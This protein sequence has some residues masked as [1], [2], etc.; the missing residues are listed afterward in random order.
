MANNKKNVSNSGFSELN[1]ELILKSEPNEIQDDKIPEFSINTAIKKENP[2]QVVGCSIEFVSI[3][4]IKN[5]VLFEDK[6]EDIGP[7]HL[8]VN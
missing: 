1:S 5:E 8:K 7:D 2:T 3:Q 6:S 4:V